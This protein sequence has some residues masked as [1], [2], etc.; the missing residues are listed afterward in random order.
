MKWRQQNLPNSGMLSALFTR[1]TSRRAPIQLNS[2]TITAIPDEARLYQQL[3]SLRASLS[4]TRHELNST[5]IALQ[6]S[7]VTVPTLQ[8]Q[9]RQAHT[10]LLMLQQEHR[11][12]AGRLHDTEVQRERQQRSMLKLRSEYSSVQAELRRHRE[13][14]QLE[15]QLARRAA[16]DSA[17]GW[18]VLLLLLLLA[19]LLV[20]ARRPTIVPL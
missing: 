4:T 17:H 15:K 8:G 9:L 1:T 10:Q 3:T 14:V 7:T 19:L 12:E 2:T 13:E 20:K 5:A 11:R 16:E 6:R 18:A